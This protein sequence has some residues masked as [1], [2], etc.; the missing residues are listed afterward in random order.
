V[1]NN[2]F[3]ACLVVNG[4]IV[5]EFGETAYLPFGSEYAIRLKNLDTRR[6]LVS[7]T[8]DGESATGG[9]QLVI[10]ANQEADLEGFL[11]AASNVARNR[12]RFIE[13]TDKIS[14]HRGDRTDDGLVRIEFQFE[15]NDPPYQTPVIPPYP[16]RKRGTPVPS[17]PWY[18]NPW[19]GHEES[20]LRSSSMTKGFAGGSAPDVSCNVGPAAAAGSSFNDASEV[21]P[22]SL[23]FAE[24]LSEPLND[25]GITV[26]GSVVNQKFGTTHVGRLDPG[27][28]SIVF[29][30]KGEKTDGVKVASP[31]LTRA[32]ISCPT[33]GTKNSSGNKFCPEC[34]TCLV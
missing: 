24:A 26:A 27:T 13:K 12:F 31:I 33:C 2:K 11:D 18:E 28:F 20:V 25:R 21:G 30:L 32:K 10:G 29:Q 19:Y 1:Y 16:P 4:K 5:R 6:A 15:S 23:G 17:R 3:V 7:V 9:T 14:E 22:Q 8:V 34:S